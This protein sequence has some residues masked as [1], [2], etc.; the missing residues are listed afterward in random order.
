WRL[1]VS[2]SEMILLVI[3]TGFVWVAEI[4]NTAIEKA[5]DL[6][7]PGYHP[8]VKLIKDLSAAAVLIAAV[9]SVITGALI[10]IP[11]FF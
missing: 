7:S 9:I 2:H 4:F 8:K 3:V 11:K 1:E 6:I 5:M 10:F